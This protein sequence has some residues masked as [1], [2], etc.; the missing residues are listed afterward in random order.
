MQ[1]ICGPDGKF[2]AV[3]IRHPGATSDYLAFATS[4]MN[5]MFS[6]NNPIH[7]DLPFLKQGLCIYGDNAYVNTNYMITPYKNVSDGPKDA[8]NFFQSQ[9][10][11]NIECAFGILVH[12]W[13]ILCKHMPVNLTIAKIGSLVLSLC[14]LH[15]FCISQRDE[16]AEVELDDDLNIMS[17]GGLHVNNEQ[18]ID[19]IRPLL[20]G[21][22]FVDDPSLQRYYGDRDDKPAKDML[23]MITE[24]GFVRPRPRG[25]SPRSGSPRSLSP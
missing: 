9:L 17:S 8:F 3:E 25:T 1:A 15:N 12:R 24:N 21:G 10:C 22:N 7:P 20:D 11:I 6:G 18:A 16:V 23:D 19:S 13:G 2:V 4:N 5:K 14:K